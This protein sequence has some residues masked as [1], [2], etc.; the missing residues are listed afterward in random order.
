MCATITIASTISIPFLDHLVLVTFDCPMIDLTVVLSFQSFVLEIQVGASSD[1]MDG[2][3]GWKIA[4][5][6]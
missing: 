2:S 6:L 5:L 3:K 4:T 1:C